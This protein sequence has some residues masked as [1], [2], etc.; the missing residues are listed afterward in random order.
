MADI[1]K[2]SLNGTN[3]DI[4]DATARESATTLE[5][6]VAAVEAQ[7][8]GASINDKRVTHLVVIGDSYGQGYLPSGNVTSYADLIATQLSLSEASGTYYNNSWGGAGFSVALQ[9]KSFINLIEEFYTGDD[10]IY[11][12][13]QR[14]TVSHVLI[15]GGWNDVVGT[16]ASASTIS[17]SVR[18]AITRARNAFPN[19]YIKVAFIGRGKEKYERQ[20]TVAWAYKVG[21]SRN[22]QGSYINK[23]EYILNNSY[24]DQSDGLHPTSNGHQILA[25]GL[26]NGLLSDTAHIRLGQQYINAVED[27]NAIGYINT[28]D[29]MIELVL[30]LRYGISYGRVATGEASTRVDLY[31]LAWDSPVWNGAIGCIPI[32]A[33][34]DNPP[35]GERHR[36][37]GTA[38]FGIDNGV[39]YCTLMV[40]GE[41]Q[42]LQVDSFNYP[43]VSF[44]L[45][46]DFMK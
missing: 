30:G 16:N 9:G 14:K 12:E 26:A 37:E 44:N 10:P 35:A 33:Y 3:Y 7:M 15:A 43:T 38:F 31:H 18:T 20:N 4:K 22:K 36:H 2:I 46:K 24:M 27:R 17:T 21:C 42:F 32:S 13:A 25:Y 11:T 45:S 28:N 39:V 34:T 8:Q 40:A 41:T 29:N 6:R 5:S 19:A 23:S 1:S